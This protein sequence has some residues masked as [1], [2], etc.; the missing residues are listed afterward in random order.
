MSSFIHSS[1]LS[2]YS[3]GLVASA[4]NVLL[5]F[6]CLTKWDVVGLFEWLRRSMVKSDAARHANAPISTEKFK[7]SLSN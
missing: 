5:G 7:V 1:H 4:A 2:P 3:E 6:A